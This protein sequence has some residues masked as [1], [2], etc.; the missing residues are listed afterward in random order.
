MPKPPAHRSA[1][2]GDTTTANRTPIEDYAFVSDRRGSALISKAGSVDWLCL[3]DFDS[4][5]SFAA[6]LGGPQHGRW[7]LAPADPARTTR[8]Y[9][10]DTLVLRTTHETETGTVAVTDFMPSSSDRADLVRRV[11]GVDGQVTMWHEWTVRPWYGKRI[12]WVRREEHDEGPALVAVAGADLL[13][14]RG[15]TLP[16]RG[17]DNVFTGTFTVSAGDVVDFDLIWQRSHLDEQPITTDVAAVLDATVAD[18]RGWLGECDYDGPYRD[19][20][21]RSLLVLRHLTHEDFGGIV[22]APTASLPEEFGGQRNWDY[23]FCWLRDAALTLEALLAAGYRDKAC[24]WRDWLVRAVAGDPTHMQI[25]YR[26]DAGHHLPEEELDH[27]PGYADSGP[28]RIGNGAVDQRQTDVLGEVMVA[29]EM[30]RHRGLPESDDTAALQAALVDDLAT[31]WDEP[32]NGIWEIRGALQ[33][34]TQSRVM[35]WAA[36]DRAIK[37]AEA[38]ELP[39][40]SIE[41]WRGVRDA[42][43]AAVDESGYDRKRNTYTQHDDTDEVDASLLLLPMVGFVDANDSRFAG[44]VKAIEEDLMRDGLLLRYRTESGVDGLEGDEHPFLICCFWLVIAYARMGRRDDAVALMD[45]LIGLR[46]DVG[47]LAE[48]SDGAGVLYG[49]FPQAF[50]HLGLVLAALELREPGASDG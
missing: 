10:E 9:V 26:I 29:L 50:S 2:D 30:A 5:A 3:P 44:T 15:P 4:P 23:R 20:V 7:L 48:E 18:D 34:F 41:T 13:V 31:H 46:N 49:N 36:M 40:A 1:T 28:V 19:D 24:V 12:P 22:A 42:A 38:G 17:P 45:R 47:L 32:D 14:L 37:A 33:H 43:R 27:L 21:R 35:V 11:E 39:G 8:A 25:M 6:L 16:D